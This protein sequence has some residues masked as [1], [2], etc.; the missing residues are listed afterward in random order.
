MRLNSV[1]TYM[2]LKNL[3]FWMKYHFSTHLFYMYI[4]L[5]T[6]QLENVL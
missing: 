2:Y 5:I 1:Y 6:T 4:I 3:I